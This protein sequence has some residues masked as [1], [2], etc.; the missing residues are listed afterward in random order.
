M[1]PKFSVRRPYTVLVAVI[2]VVVLGVV[3]FLGMSTDLLPHIDL[4]YI[5]VLTTYPGASPEKVEIAVTKPLEAVLGTASGLN[6]ISSISMENSSMI[7]LEFVQG[8]NMDSVM[9]ELSG[10]LDRVRGRLDSAVGSPMM[11]KIS[12]DMMPVMIASVDLPDVSLYDLAKIT[13][14]ELIPAFERVEGVASVT[15]AGLLE[16]H[17]EVTLNSEK[18]DKLNQQIIADINKKLDEKEAELEEALKKLEDGKASLESELPK[19]RDQL[20]KAGS[21]TSEA[22]SKVQALLAEEAELEAQKQAF[23][24]KKAML[25]ELTKLEPLFSQYFQ[26]VLTLSPEQFQIMME[27]MATQIP[28]ELLADSPYDLF[29]LSQEELIALSEQI[30]HA[31]ARLNAIEAELQ[32]IEIRQMTLQAMKPQLEKGLEEARKGAEQIE[33]AKI[34][35]AIETAKAQMQIE[36]SLAEIEKAR[37]EFESAREQAIEKANLSEIIN[38]KMIVNLLK[39]Q[40]FSMPAGS[41]REGADSITVKIGEEYANQHDLEEALLLSHDV[42]GDVRLKDIAE[43]TLKDNAAETY[44]K[45]NGNNGI[46]ISFQKLS[47]A[48]TADVTKRIHEKT[49]ELNKEYEGLRVL[50]LMDQGEYINIIINS[51]LNNLLMGGVLAIIV[52]FLF[53]LD[54]RPTLVVAISIPVSLLFA[55]AL[56]YFTNISINIISLSGL[57][58]GV[59]MLVDNSIVVIEN[60]Y[61]L[62][63]N[64]IPPARAAITGANQV[65]AAITSSTLTTVCVFLPIVF[66]H[67]LTR[68]LFTDMG[69]TIT[70][71]LLASLIVAL[72]VVPA[73]SA[74]TMRHTKDKEYRFFEWLK[75][76]YERALSFSLKHKAA[77]L[78]PVVILFAL[79]IYGAITMGTAFLPEMDSPQLS[80]T[81]V[82]PEDFSQE[83]IYEAADQVTERI[84]SIEAVDYVGAI[85]GTSSIIS[86]GQQQDNRSILF[87]ILLKDERDLTNRDVEKL[88]YEKTSDLPGD[89]SVSATTMD[90]SVLG[91]SGI[92]IQ[93]RGQDFD[94]M[95]LVLE[96]VKTLL[97]GNEGIAEIKTS[98]DE[99]AKELRVIVDKDKAMRKGLT[100]AQIYQQLS[101]A[102]QEEQQAIVLTNGSNSLPVLLSLQEDEKLTRQKL[103]DFN[104]TWTDNEG[105]KQS[106]RLGEIAQI[107]EAPAMQAIRR[108]NQSRYL[109]VSAT[110]K[111][112]YNIGLV[113]RELE[114]KLDEIALPEGISLKL[115]GENVLIKEAMNDLYLMIALAVIFIYLIMVAQFQ[116]LRAPFI[117]IFTLPLAFT[118]G[119]LLLWALGMELSVIA[120]IGF[121]LLAGIVVNNG[122]VFVS[123]VNQLREEGL[124]RTTALLQTGKIRLRPILMTALTTILAMIT[125]ALGMGQGAELTQPMAV[126]TIGGLSYATLLTLF[127]IPIVYDIFHKHRYQP[128][129]I[130]SDGT[131]SP[132]LQ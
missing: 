109:T 98:I 35:L 120:L 112:G 92:S 101:E 7:I 11:L 28:R 59:G 60:I 53:L 13:Q 118:G 55:L 114:P 47:T 70:F 76:S 64:G 104:L 106:L 97:Q 107:E 85:H 125:M 126:V 69:L 132:E 27:Q 67:G 110:L 79:S 73:L 49:E 68:Q 10:Y 87:Y 38:N 12:P 14:D 21:Q 36:N 105:Q 29:S 23:E 45:I 48:S 44:A 128:I 20:I 84:L 50:P 15:A 103:S 8:S 1:L 17:I 22:I 108:E 72:T 119:L 77:I 91:E 18:I 130:N 102:L 111:A 124:D 54:P 82:L 30:S 121:L 31:H 117:V 25:T 115:G 39:A 3:S 58:L 129:D 99:E 43:I 9:I 116:S 81:L 66:T 65:S 41:L 2:L 57:A 80:A 32:N 24:R 131:E 88:I 19:Q 46:V 42:I 62:R 26:K 95:R 94:Q 86:L 63:H 71:S 78:I 123:T 100:I 4:P 40:H 75:S 16:Q 51:V 127:V 37:A 5:V 83:M 113:S 34:T 90:L 96:D 56:M 52:L 93:I 61:R 89:I 74:T 122:I 6:N 33:Q